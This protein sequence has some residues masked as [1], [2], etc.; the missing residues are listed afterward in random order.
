M[1]WLADQVEGLAKQAS[2]ITMYDIKSVVNQAKNIVMNFTEMEAKVR[3]ATN[4][5]AW[6]ASSTLMQDIAQGTFNFQLFNEIMPTIYARFTEKEA[7]QWRQIY[8]ALVLLEY[9]VKNGSERVIDDA[10]TH[11]SLIKVL[12]NF[13]YT[14]ENGKDQGINVRNRSKELAELLGDLDRVRQERRKAKANRNKYTG[15]SSDGFG[16]GGGGGGGPSFTSATGSRYGGFGSDSMGSGSG[17]G[18]EG[19]D[20]GGF[21]DSRA[22]AGD[23][24]EYDAGDWEDKPSRSNSA[25]TR[26]SGSGS[27]SHSRA[28]ASV[29]PTPPAP[30]PAPPKAEVNL[31]DFDDEDDQPTPPPK[32]SSFAAPASA[33]A[34]LDD[35]FDDF[36]SAAPTPSVPSLPISPVSAAPKQNAFAMLNAQPSTQIRPPQS[37]PNSGMMGSF[38]PMQA[39]SAIRPNPP[40][41]TNS[42]TSVFSQNSTSA[43]AA[44]AAQVKPKAAAAD[45]SDLF[46][47]FGGAIAPAAKSG[48]ANGGMTIA[49]I[50]EKK[51]QES[52]FN[53]SNAGVK[54][55]SYGDGGASSTDD[56]GWG[57]L[58]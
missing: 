48:S 1:N 57:S 19:G 8:K 18:R 36:Q 5:D 4:D 2:E 11:L 40:S 53:M 26:A 31:F 39:Q 51:R 29:K 3:D 17:G 10:R 54:T 47:S 45:F 56:N 25:P 34:S 41:Q 21:S 38:A 32:A 14:D 42:T 7:R 23:F 37:S 50:A 24:E 43:S 30:K 20:H 16:G 35:D 33:A 12:R 15:V 44:A 28:S 46:G 13:H 55:Q 22:P 27:G 6:G 58:L 52:L 9:L 49:Q